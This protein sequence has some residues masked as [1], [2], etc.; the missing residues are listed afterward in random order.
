M[1]DGRS[2]S[3]KSNEIQ[4]MRYWAIQADCPDWKLKAKF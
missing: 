4:D 3:M 1:M 2:A